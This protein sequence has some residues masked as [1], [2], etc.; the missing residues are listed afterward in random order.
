MKKNLAQRMRERN[1][2]RKAKLSA[3]K[4]KAPQ[5][6]VEEVE[7]VEDA[8]EMEHEEKTTRK[9]RSYRRKKDQ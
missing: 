7:E 6:V 4:G 3:L 1:A 2:R 8:A 5:E 9:K